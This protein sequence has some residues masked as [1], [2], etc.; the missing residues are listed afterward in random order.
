MPCCQVV[1]GALSPAPR[2]RVRRPVPYS[3]DLL[4]I[5]LTFVS[6]TIIRFEDATA[7]TIIASYVALAAVLLL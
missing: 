2:L 5:L 1:R 6:E 7:Y 3:A 4:T